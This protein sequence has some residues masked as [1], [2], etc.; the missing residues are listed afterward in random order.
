MS[1]SESIKVCLSKYFVVAGRASRSEFWWFYSIHPALYAAFAATQSEVFMV[2]IFAISIP[3]LTAAVRRMHDVD[4][5]GWFMLIPIYNLVLAVTK[6]TP[7]PNRFDHVDV[8]NLAPPKIP[9]GN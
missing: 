6:G 1:F 7:G 8:S 3:L 9:N 4:K 5:S 2:G